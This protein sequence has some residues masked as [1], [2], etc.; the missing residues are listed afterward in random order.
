M[1]TAPPPVEPSELYSKTEVMR[2][3]NL[4]EHQFICAVGNGDLRVQKD[5][6]EHKSKST[7]GYTNV[8]DWY[9]G[10]DILYHY[11]KYRNKNN[12]K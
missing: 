10:T 6:K 8:Q 7:T 4:T 11:F 2:L 3:L 12:K 1:I 9:K 5:L